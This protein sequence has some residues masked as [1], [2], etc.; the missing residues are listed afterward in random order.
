MILST[1]ILNWYARDLKDRK[2]LQGVLL[3]NLLIHLFGV[4]FD[5]VGI[6]QGNINASGW[7]SVVFRGL[8]ALGFLYFLI[9]NPAKKS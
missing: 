1:A 9:K 8:L 4:S 6:T 3:T 7:G 2:M 5:I